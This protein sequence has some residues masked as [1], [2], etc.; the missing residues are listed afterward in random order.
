MSTQVRKR[1][2]PRIS[3]SDFRYFR[4]SI[5]KSKK[6]YP[7]LDK[8]GNHFSIFADISLCPKVPSVFLFAEVHSNI[9]FNVLSP[10]EILQFKFELKKHLTF[11]KQ[12]F[13]RVTLLHIT[14]V[15]LRVR[16]HLNELN[17]EL[18]RTI[19]C[20]LQSVTTTSYSL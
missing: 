6:S 12:I 17:R 14:H 2:F 20:K 13:T 9:L 18:I 10:G 8:K 7:V 4:T 19:H 5:V 3:E 1:C 16:W 11:T 15:S